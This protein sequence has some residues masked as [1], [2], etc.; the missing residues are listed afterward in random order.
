MKL[1]KAQHL[2]AEF[3]KTNRPGQDETRVWQ[4]HPVVDVVD[5]FL[6][7]CPEARAHRSELMIRPRFS[8]PDLRQKGP[9]LVIG[10]RYDTEL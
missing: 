6:R 7:Q 2:L 5:A 1:R 3:T 8:Q 4:Y 10:L 9:G